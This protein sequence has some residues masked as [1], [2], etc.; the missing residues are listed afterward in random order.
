MREEQRTPHDGRQRRLNRKQN[1]ESH[2][3]YRDKHNDKT[4]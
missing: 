2:R 4:E 3:I 1:P